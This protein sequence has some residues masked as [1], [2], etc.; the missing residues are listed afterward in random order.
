MNIEDMTD[1]Q[2]GLLFDVRRSIRY[3]DRRRAFFETL[4]RITSAL[5]ILLVGWVLSSW[6]GQAMYRSG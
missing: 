2:Y 3:H 5:T 1:A 6:P 4:H